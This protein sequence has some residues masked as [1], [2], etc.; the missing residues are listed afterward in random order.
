[1]TQKFAR[2]LVDEEAIAHAASRSKDQHWFVGDQR[3][4]KSITRVAFSPNGKRLAWSGSD[5]IVIW[6]FEKGR[7]ILMVEGHPAKFQGL[8]FSPDG[9]RLASASPDALL[10]VWDTNTGQESIGFE[11]QAQ[12]IKEETG[13]ITDS[14]GKRS[15]TKQALNQ[16]LTLAYSPNDEFIAASYRTPRVDASGITIWSASTGRRMLISRWTTTDGASS[17]TALPL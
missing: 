5:R 7:E 11:G 2:L 9:T 13:S 8:A 10:R 15:V 17:T 6:D 14:D 4:N 16:L 1:M 12:L 3:R